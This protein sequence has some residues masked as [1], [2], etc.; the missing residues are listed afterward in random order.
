MIFFVGILVI[1]VVA[2]LIIS[3][4]CILYPCFLTKEQIALL[5]VMAISSGVLIASITYLRDKKKHE[6]EEALK[7]DELLLKIAKEGFDEVYNLI[8]E[9]DNSRVKWIRAARVLLN[10]LDIERLIVTPI[11]KRSY[12]THME[13]TRINLYQ[14]LLIPSQNPDNSDDESLPPHFFYGIKDWKENT[15]SLDEASKAARSTCQAFRISIDKVT[16]EPKL[17]ELDP[18]SVIAI[19][20]FVCDYDKSY[21]DILSQ[22]NEWDSDYASA[23]G[24]KQGPARYIAHTNK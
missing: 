12:K 17:L 1:I 21:S 6:N 16:P 7:N 15:L 20:D 2:T 8:Y 4:C 5:P 11:I 24:I 14:S 9:Q 19:Y 22:V 10:T 18:R 3:I 23:F 13:Y